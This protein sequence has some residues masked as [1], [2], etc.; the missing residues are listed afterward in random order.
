MQHQPAPAT[1]VHVPEGGDGGDESRQMGQPGPR[2]E[3]FPSG[4]VFE[5]SEFSGNAG[6]AG[7][8]DEEEGEKEA[9]IFEVKEV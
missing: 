1:P 6:N 9:D 8:G 4:S 3:R 2:N 5:P 7:E